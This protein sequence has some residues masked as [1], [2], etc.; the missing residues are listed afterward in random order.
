[1]FEIHDGIRQ[2]VVLSPTLFLLIMD[3]T[4]MATQRKVR[5]LNIVYNQQYIS[6]CIVQAYLLYL[7]IRKNDY[8]DSPQYGQKI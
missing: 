4:I 3:G 8:E 5:K 2:G 7:W 6:V 1:M